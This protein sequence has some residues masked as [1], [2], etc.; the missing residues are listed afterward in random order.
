M[1]GLQHRTGCSKPDLVVTPLPGG[2]EQRCPECGKAA[3]IGTKP[4]GGDET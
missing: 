4:D 3:L 1:R 2:E